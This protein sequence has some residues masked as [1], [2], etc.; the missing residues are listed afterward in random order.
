MSQPKTDITTRSTP[1]RALQAR[2]VRRVSMQYAD[3]AD[4]R[5]D[6]PAH[7]RAA[8]S[9]AW[10]G[11]RVALVQD[12]VNFVALVDPATGLADAITLPAG[13]D[14]KRQFDDGRDNKKY[15]L[16]LEAMARVPTTRG[17]MLVAFGSG[18]KKRRENVLTLGFSG[19]LKRPAHHDPSLVAS[20]RLYEAL[21][22][23]RTFSGSDMNIEGA[24]Y[25]DG[26]IRLYG[27]G[28]GE[29]KDDLLAVNATC[30]LAWSSLQR[31]LAD[32]E[33]GALPE[34][35]RIR[36]YDLGDV[37]GVAL[38]FT[39]AIPVRRSMVLYA[40]AAEASK[41]ATEDGAVVGSALGVLPN[42]R[43]QP[44]RW[45]MLRDERGKPFAGKVEGLVLDPKDATRALV[46][47]DVDDYTRPSELCEVRLGGPW[48]GR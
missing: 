41:D 14:D 37:D 40:A 19:R 35:S 23:E 2:I 18:S 38:G 46:V 32:P 11:D 1:D 47:L 42:D 17:T 48:F 16:D 21:R 43:R 15:K 33:H 25:V 13:R 3:G 20:P 10:I 27:R 5:L 31:Y 4:E 45:A 39:D 8:S 22:A 24:L 26:M 6:R 7:V 12:D 44:A 36:Q 29:A 28:N 34:V 9:M 30:D